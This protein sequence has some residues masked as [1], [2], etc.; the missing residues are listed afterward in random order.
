M[1]LLAYASGFELQGP[2]CR[3]DLINME[4]LGL[5]LLTYS[6]VD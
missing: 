4:C 5:P 1:C 6:P 2:F 3:T